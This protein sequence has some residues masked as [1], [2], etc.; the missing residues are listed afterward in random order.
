MKAEECR[1]SEAL[2]R[3]DARPLWGD[4]ADHLGNA[5]LHDIRML[6]NFDMDSQNKAALVLAGLDRLQAMLA[7]PQHEP[8][9]QRVVANVRMRPL[10]QQEMRGYVEA[11]AKAAGSS[12]DFLGE[13][14]LQA[15]ANASRGLPRVADQILGKAC[16]LADAAGLK[17]VTKD[18]VKDAIS[19]L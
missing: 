10:S 5:V 13:G 7:S 2:S 1:V 16:M 12:L 6:M 8:L 15:V 18:V 4:E 19:N 17:Q 3:F 14:A 11:K 9:A